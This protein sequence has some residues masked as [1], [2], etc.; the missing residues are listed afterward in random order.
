[1]VEIIQELLFTNNCVIIPGFGAFIGN[2]NPAEI[3][4]SENKIFPPSK[5][6]AFNRSLQANDG[7]LIN[8]TS[9]YFSISYKDAEEKINAFAKNCN[10]TL[11]QHKSIIFKNIGR[12]TIDNDDKIQFQ[13]FYIKNYLPESFGL[14][15][16]SI[17]P[18]HRLKDAEIELKENYQRVMHPELTEDAISPRSSKKK[19][20]LFAIAGIVFVAA[21]LSLNINKDN[22]NKSYASLLPMF[23]N[24]KTKEYILPKAVESQ[25]A[26]V[27]IQNKIDVATKEINE[28]DA[29]ISDTTT[30]TVFA[31]SKNRSYIIVGTFFDENRAEK[32]K[33]ES[34]KIGYNTSI[35]IDN[36]DGLFRVT[37][38]VE[39]KE[40]EASLNKIK[41]TLNPRAWVYCVKCNLK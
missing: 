19:Y 8:Y 13:P 41:S 37:V 34:D 39:N 40:L 25:S 15:I 28:I 5:L 32:L 10:E 22:S 26:S 2:Y 3:R 33:S 20:W 9:H 21:L 4:L 18:I 12:L 11:L 7:L 36:K 38:A 24:A 14:E 31:K 29:A 23:D 1:M 35:S 6:I 30:Q 17:V 16:M 27:F